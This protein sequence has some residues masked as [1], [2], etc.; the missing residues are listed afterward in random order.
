MATI[1]DWEDG[2]LATIAKHG[3]PA[4]SIPKLAES[5]DVTKGSFYWHFSSLGDLV[6]ASLKRWEEMDRALLADLKA[7]ADPRARLRA[8]FEQSMERRE[9]QALFVA[10]SSSPAREVATALNRI[11]KRRLDFLQSAYEELGMEEAADR[12][13]LAYS[14][15]IGALHLKITKKKDVAAFIAHAEKTLI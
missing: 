4:L 10:L 2:A 14:A 3:L 6:A 12:A 11:S 15:Y 7:I 8:L 9:A 5:L 13:L 1:E